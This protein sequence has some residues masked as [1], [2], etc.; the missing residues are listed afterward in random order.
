MTSILSL[1]VFLSPSCSQMCASYVYLSVGMSVYTEV[2]GQY[3]K[4]S[5]TFVCVFIYL[6]FVCLFRTRSLLNTA[7]LA[8]PD[9]Q[10][11][12]DASCLCFPSAGVTG[13][14]YHTQ[15]FTWCWGP[16]LRSSCSRGK[17]FPYGALAPDLGINHLPLSSWHV[18]VSCVSSEHPAQR[19]YHYTPAQVLKGRELSPRRQCSCSRS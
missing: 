12:P 6:L 10:Q 3:Q 11:A 5:S 1:S 13:V 15:T 7:N 14:C 18:S 8:R 17:P 4:S 9:G 19:P 16:Q 2:K